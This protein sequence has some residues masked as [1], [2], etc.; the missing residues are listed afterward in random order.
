MRDRPSRASGGLHSYR[1][2]KSALLMSCQDLHCPSLKSPVGSFPFPV[3]WS[4]SGDLF[5]EGFHSLQLPASRI[6]FP[7]RFFMLVRIYQLYLAVLADTDAG[8]RNLNLAAPDALPACDYLSHWTRGI[9][10]NNKLPM[11][12]L[13]HYHPLRCRHWAYRNPAYLIRVVAGFK[14]GGETGKY[15]VFPG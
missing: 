10:S 1:R 4:R 7:R 11:L 5:H 8:L 12:I 15:R 14:D 6:Q 9:S 2:R 3:V 13:F